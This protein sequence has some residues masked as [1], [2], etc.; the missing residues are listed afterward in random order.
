MDIWL[1]SARLCILLLRIYAT[2]TNCTVVLF[3]L[4]SSDVA[5][6]TLTSIFCSEKRY[7]SRNPIS[8]IKVVNWPMPFANH[9]IARNTHPRPWNCFKSCQFYSND[10][11]V[12][13]L[14]LLGAI[15]RRS[16]ASSPPSSA[17]SQALMTPSKSPFARRPLRNSFPYE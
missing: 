10:R 11:I 6:M 15:V 12:Y 13:M 5:R 17:R 1:F 9:C 2:T 8:R 14:A 16:F 7:M 4:Y 3:L